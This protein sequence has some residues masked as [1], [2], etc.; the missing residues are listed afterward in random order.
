MTS[1]CR[2]GPQ[3]RSCEIDQCSAPDLNRDS[4]T[5]VC[6]AGPQRASSCCKGRECSPSMLRQDALQTAEMGKSGS[7]SSICHLGVSLYINPSNKFPTNRKNE[8]GPF[9]EEAQLEE[10][11][12]MH[13]SFSFPLAL[14]VCCHEAIAVTPALL[15]PLR[16]MVTMN[17]MIL[18]ARNPKMWDK[19]EELT[20]A[21]FSRRTPK[22]S[23]E[24]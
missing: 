12:R 2:A 11:Q 7:N 24:I 22:T 4:V 21:F 6:R 3:P 1:V 16:L 23:K 9:L 14:R 20:P 10:L 13:T 17:A 18:L 8:H 19:V 5:S 15:E